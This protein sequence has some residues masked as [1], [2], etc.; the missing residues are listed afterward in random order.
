MK[1]PLAKWLAILPWRQKNIRHC[2]ISGP[3]VNVFKAPIDL[4]SKMAK[5][6][7]VEEILRENL[8]AEFWQYKFTPDET[9]VG[10]DVPALIPSNLVPL[11]EEFLYEH[12][13]NLVGDTDCDLLFPNENGKMMFENGL[14]YLVGELTIRHAGK[15]LSPHT[16]RHIVA[17][18]WLDA[19]PEDYLTLSMLLWHT[20]INTTIRIYGCRFDQSNAMCRME[21]WLAERKRK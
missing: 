21:K 4:M 13:I 3:S 11:L 14:N 2:R 12:R 1:Q 9:K 7:W 20:N 19:H 10:N 6:D 5:F 16:Y 8:K 15:R 18:T 17:Y